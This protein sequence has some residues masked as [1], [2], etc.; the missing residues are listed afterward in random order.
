MKVLNEGSLTI[1]L[2]SEIT[3][4]LLQEGTVRDIVRSIQNLRKE[5]KLEVTDRITIKLSGSE[6][7]VDA[8]TSFMD[9]LLTETLADS[10]S[11]EKTPESIEMVWG[12]ITCFIDLN[13][14]L[15]DS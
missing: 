15:T 14:S 1:G 12:E 11:W 4:E 2:D 3:E 13:K 7:L 9:H 5:R 6:W 8:V 10:L